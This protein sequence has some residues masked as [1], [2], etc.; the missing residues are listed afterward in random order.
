MSFP[1]YPGYKDSGVQWIGNVPEHWDVVRLRNIFLIQKRI[2]GKLGFDVLSITNKG[3]KVKDIESGDGQLSSDYSKYQLVMKGEF[4]MNH[5]DLVT[6]YVDI[7]AFDGVTSPDYRVFSAAHPELD[8]PRFMLRLLQNAYHQKLFFPFGQGSAHLGRWRLPAEEFKDFF[9]PRPSRS[10]QTQIARFLDHETARI[11]ALIEEQQRLIE[12][13]KEKRQAVIS[14]AVTKGLDPMVPMKDSGVEW[15]GEVPAHWN[16][17]TLRWYATIQGGVAKGK[18]YEGRETVVMPYLRVANVQNGYVDFT[19]VKEIAVLESE[20]ER[21]RLRAGDVLMNEGGDNDKL[22]RGTV[23]QAQIDPCLH[24][25]HVFAIRPNGLLRAE[26]LAAFTQSEQARTYFY[27]NSKQ[28]T[29]LA[30]ISASNVMSLALP[31]PSASEQLEIL[32]YLEKDRIRHEQLTGV[33]VSTVELL[34]ERRSALISAA[35]TGK[36]DVRGWRPPARTQAPKFEVAEA[37]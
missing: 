17:G 30:S 36:I 25:N 15:L 19:E 34:Q 37:V 13:L 16:V 14:Q 27:L 20:V 22:G 5:M 9:F 23:W 6:G 2:A 28:S 10:E 32:T 8:S 4:A 26:W 1:A 3:V 31:I 33:A 29:N 11:D 7:S 18:D 24:Q 35:V 12:L 21:Y